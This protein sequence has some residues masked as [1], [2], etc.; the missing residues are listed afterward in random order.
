MIDLTEDFDIQPTRRSA[1]QEEE[2]DTPL[3]YDLADSDD[4]E[5]DGD[6]YIRELTPDEFLKAELERLSISETVSYLKGAKTEAAVT[7]SGFFVQAGTGVELYHQGRQEYFRVREL[8]S[9]GKGEVQMKGILLM[10]TRL[11]MNML[12]KKYNELCAI[13]KARAD[14]SKIPEVD[15]HLVTRPLSSVICTRKIIFTNQSFPTHSFRDKGMG[16]NTWDDVEDKAE[17][18]CRYKQVEFCNTVNWNVPSEALVRLRRHECDVGVPDSQLMLNWC[19]TKKQKRPS[20]ERIIDMTQDEDE[21][22]E[23][24]SKV[25]KTFKRYNRNGVYERRTNS[26]VTERYTPLRNAFKYKQ[27]PKTSSANGTETSIVKAYLYGDV[28]AGAGGATTAAKRAGFHVKFALDHAEDPCAT[29]RENFPGAEILE[30]DIFEFC[31]G[32]HGQDMRV[33]VLHISFPCQTYSIAHTH[34]GK[35]DERNEAAG[36]S[37]IPL[38]KKCRPRIVTFEQ[39]P[40]ITKEKHRASFEALIH[41]I[42]EMGYSVR[43]KVVSFA[44]TGNAQSRNRL[45]I[46]A[47][48]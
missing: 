41:Q 44:D 14:K 8:F 40:N 43:W 24:R 6:E 4:D 48:W 13:I 42:T 18:V 21:V 23:V 28:C 12:P 19:S 37:V 10:R 29:L 15:D 30:M 22:R 11:V 9:D 16:Y 31:N 2:E 17:L 35:N 32:E 33:D 39:S 38:L 47:A 27:V 46:I 25:Q 26:V 34:P 3:I 45:F 7:A 1:M 20:T 36:Y 5:D